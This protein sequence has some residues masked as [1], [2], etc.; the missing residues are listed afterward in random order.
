MIHAHLPVVLE[1]SSCQ[2]CAVKNG[3]QCMDTKRRRWMVGG[4]VFG[5]IRPLRVAGGGEREDG[6]GPD[7]AGFEEVCHRDSSGRF[8]GKLG[9]ARLTTS[10]N[11]PG[12]ESPDN[13]R[14]KLRLISA[15]LTLNSEPAN[16]I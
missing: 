6:Q 9:C 16:R 5:G 12:L 2:L 8:Y 13:S 11:G 1:V 15:I 7:P 14:E 4:N 3:R 10:L